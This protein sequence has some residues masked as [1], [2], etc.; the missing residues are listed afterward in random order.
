MGALAWLTNCL[1]VLGLKSTKSATPPNPS[2]LM[3]EVPADYTTFKQALS[4]QKYTRNF[5]VPKQVQ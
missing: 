3:L 1:Q 2:I 4:K 5:S